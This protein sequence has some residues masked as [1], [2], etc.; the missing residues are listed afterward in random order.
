ML[1]VQW[2]R[3]RLQTRRSLVRFSNDSD[4]TLFVSAAAGK[5]GVQ[6]VLE[7]LLQS[8][9]R[10]LVL[11]KVI[12]MQ[13]FDSIALIKEGKIQGLWKV[14]GGSGGNG[15]GGGVEINPRG[16][17]A[18]RAAAAAERFPTKGFS[19]GRTSGAQAAAAER[20]SAER[21]LTERF[22]VEGS[23]DGPTASCSSAP[24]HEPGSPG[25][26]VCRG[27]ESVGAGS[28]GAESGAEAVSGPG[29]VSEEVWEGVSEEISESGQRPGGE[30]DWR[31][32]LAAEPLG[33]AMN[34]GLE[35]LGA[36]LR[37]PDGVSKVRP[38]L[39]LLSTLRFGRS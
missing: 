30:V 39:E 12:V 8:G 22:P 7:H 21:F 16:R 4:R 33:G 24:T 15:G 18:G 25:V 3:L 36:D 1:V 11:S 38:V 13:L 14:G 28:M 29:G 2:L 6:A 17:S 27:E 10:D 34:P 19:R 31:L 9:T 37:G 26:S 5:A 32:G 35:V 23:L 20:L